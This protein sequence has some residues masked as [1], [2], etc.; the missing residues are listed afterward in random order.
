MPADGW[1]AVTCAGM[2]MLAGAAAAHAQGDGAAAPPPPRAVLEVLRSGPSA[3]LPADA[4]A[5]LQR[6]ESRAPGQHIAQRPTQTRRTGP[7]DAAL[8]LV[9]SRNGI[10]VLRHGRGVCSDDLAAIAEQGLRFSIAHRREPDGDR[11]LDIYGV[12]PD[13]RGT[14]SV[15]VDREATVRGT[16]AHDNGYRFRLPAKTDFTLLTGPGGHATLGPL[17]S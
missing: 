13:G 1:G 10:C 17:G 3:T 12:V 7:R 4:R 5:T 9:A 2:L 11:P 16:N 8:Y 6:L 14:V 15:Q